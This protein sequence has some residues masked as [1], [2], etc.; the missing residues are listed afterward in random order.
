MI[1]P[2]SYKP[3][4]SPSSHVKSFD[5]YPGAFLVIDGPRA[6]WA[7]VDVGGLQILDL[8]DGTLTLA[9]VAGVLADRQGAPVAEALERA[10]AF[11]AVMI[12]AGLVYDS[13]AG[14]PKVVTHESCFSGLTIEITKRCNFHCRHCYLAAGQ[15]A[16]HELTLDEI[17]D[18]ISEAKRLG[19]TFVNLS[20][21]EP[22][23]REGCLSLLEHI[24]ALGLQ[25]VIGTNGSTVSPDVARRLAELS[26]FVQLS[27]DGASSATHDAVR[28]QGAFQRTRQGLDNLVQAGMANRVMLAFTST[29]GNV[30]EARAPIDLALEKGLRGVIFTSL[31]AGGNAQL[32]WEDLKLSNEQ[33][34]RLWEFI[35]TQARDLAGRLV[36]L[37]QGLFVRLDD[38]GVSHFVCSIGTNLRVDPEGNV[39]P[40]QCFVGGTEYRLG[41]VREQT[42]EE[43]VTGPRLQEIKRARYQRVLLI[44]RCR[45]CAWSQYCGGGCMGHAYHKEG[46]ILATPDCKVRAAWVHRL[47]ELHL[48]HCLQS[49]PVL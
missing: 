28:G 9:E 16:E 22:L 49:D 5:D 3:V 4:L 14:L 27:L 12:E 25:S 23:L 17:K 45:Q 34:L 1:T 18:L 39:Y 2:I 47:F 21:G 48:A 46:T 31:L 10:E 6:R 24:K 36:I 40:C 37:H 26:T 13:R 35:A 7:F 43:L 29:A 11:L 33:A 41:N 44:E 20:G 19:A 8:C 32:N 15:E 38:P 42:L 30:H